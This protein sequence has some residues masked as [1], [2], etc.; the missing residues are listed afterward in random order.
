VFGE[1]EGEE[2]RGKGQIGKE[3]EKRMGSEREGKEMRTGKALRA[4]SATPSKNPKT[5]PA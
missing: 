3:R 1:G 2:R 4:P 5:A